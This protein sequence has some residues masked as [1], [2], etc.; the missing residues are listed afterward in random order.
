MSHLK[1]DRNPKGAGRPRKSASANQHGQRRFFM[2]EKNDKT[3][4]LMKA[5]HAAHRLE[6][7]KDGSDA[8]VLRAALTLYSQTTGVFAIPHPFEE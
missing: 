8:Q 3:V 4:A 7:G 5:A 1:T 6:T 2:L